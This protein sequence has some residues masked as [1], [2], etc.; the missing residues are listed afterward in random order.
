[1]I[2]LLFVI[3]TCLSGLS[4]SYAKDVHVNGYYRKNGTY[5]A[6]HFRSAPDSTKLNNFSTKGNINPYTGKKGTINPY[7]NGG[8]LNNI[9]NSNSPENFE[10]KNED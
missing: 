8:S 3:L 4:F 5:V 7:E 2:K 9:N 6:P 1:M 10:E